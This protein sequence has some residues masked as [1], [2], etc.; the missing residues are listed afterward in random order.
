MQVM[1]VFI[2]QAAPSGL[3]RFAAFLDSDSKFRIFR[4]FGFL[5]TRLLLYHQDIL[6]DIEARLEK[7]DFE[8]DS[9]ESTKCFL[10]SRSVDDARALPQRKA[11]FVE[12]E[13]ELR[14]YGRMCAGVD[15]FTG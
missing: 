15:L 12:L 11:L 13:A 7:L 5:R 4:R 8:D 9:Y 2:V 14:I 6:R 1:A 10:K 3:P